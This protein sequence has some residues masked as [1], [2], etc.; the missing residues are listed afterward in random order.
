MIASRRLTDPVRDLPRLR[1]LAARLWGP[2]ARIHP[3][4]LIWMR[5]Q[6]TGRE[7]EWPTAWWEQDGR[8]VAWAWLDLSGG[9]Q[10]QVDP[11]F[12]GLAGEVV[13]WCAAEAGGAALTA[14]IRDAET[15]AARA[16]LERGFTRRD[17]GPFF[18]HMRRDLTDVPEPWVPAGYRL[19]PV[20]DASDAPGRAAVHRAAFSLPGL[21]PSRVDTAAYREL[22]R[23]PGYLP[24]LDWIVEH[25]GEPVAF[26]LVWYDARIDTVC[27]EPVG[28]APEHRRHGLATAAILAALRAARTLGARHARV[29]ARGDD[30]YPSARA[31]Y[32]SIGF[33]AYGVNHGYHRPAADGS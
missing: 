7:P 12:P 2:D 11:A 13:D 10:F 31:L 15:W 17:G 20:R 14:T 29:C 5:F 26:C 22:M 28:C 1:E 19:R 25:D 6:H 16:L 23:Q 18:V 8:P 27:L 24:G 33:R 30:A 4:E 21:P 32:G 9:F 3:G